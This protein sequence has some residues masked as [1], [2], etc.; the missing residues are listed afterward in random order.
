MHQL[1]IRDSTIII[2]KNPLAVYHLADLCDYKNKNKLVF[3]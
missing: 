1:E 3:N 2:K